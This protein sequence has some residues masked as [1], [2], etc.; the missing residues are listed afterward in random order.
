MKKET[1][2][3]R[4]VAILLISLTALFV[5][6]DKSSANRSDGDVVSTD[7]QSKK[8]DGVTEHTHTWQ[9]ATCTTPK[10][11]SGCSATEGTELGHL[12]QNATCTT[13]KTCSACRATEGAELGHLWQDATCTT[14]KTCT[15]CRATEGTVS[16]H[17]YD[18]SISVEATCQRE[19]TKK[20]TCSK[21]QTSY[22]ESYE[23]KTYTATEIHDMYAD[24]V[25]EVSTYDKSGNGVA[26][27]S[28]FVYSADGKIV[29]NYHVIEGAYSIEIAL[30]GTTYTVQHVLAYDKDVDIA[31]LQINARDL[32][33]SDIC[34][35]THKVGATVYAY[36]SSKGLTATF[37]QGIITYADREMDGVHYTQ[38]DAAIS[39]GNSGGPLI[40]QYGEVIGINTLTIRDSQNLNFAINIS[41]L[42][43]LN[44]S[45]KLTVAQF[46]EKECDVFSKLVNYVKSKGTY[47]ASDN[48]YELTLGYEY[49]SDYSSQ[50]TRELCYDVSDHE[51]TFYLYINAEYL[52]TISIDEIDGV[53][54]WIY[55]DDNDYYML[56]TLYAST[57][58]SGSLLG[59]SDHNI[60]YA[61][62]R[63][64][65]RELASSMARLLC[66]YMSTDLA[67][68]GVTAKDLGFSNF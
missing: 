57:F 8:T 24:S 45:T 17:T 54:S 1:V 60:N 63:T 68:A 61:S 56:G 11:C 20:Y 16:E 67:D 27:G 41:Q 2:F 19:G 62:L 35:E 30:G 34:E 28:C 13:P 14:P 42:S 37:S 32:A 52:V 59:Y 36:G 64:S 12:W 40:N 5:S 22:T 15:A 46:Y 6:C 31:V 43:D 10:T 51:L 49:S 25:G 23:V 58:D 48:E 65:V 38:H 50:Y 21:C 53:Y 44:Y 4:L 18:E 55:V 26:L 47:D 29:T 7:P 3:L 39:S 9:N 33:V 66:L